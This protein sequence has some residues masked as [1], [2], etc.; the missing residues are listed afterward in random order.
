MGRSSFILI[1]PGRMPHCTR[2]LPTLTDSHLLIVMTDPDASLNPATPTG[3]GVGGTR[4]SLHP[5][6]NFTTGEGREGILD[7]GRAKYCTKRI[8]RERDRE[9]EFDRWIDRRIDRWMDLRLYVI[10]T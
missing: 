2:E 4:D 7:L 5:A 6:W 10:R 8:Q 3:E 1:L 9:R